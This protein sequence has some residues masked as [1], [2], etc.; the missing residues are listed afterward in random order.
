MPTRQ[1]A[2]RVIRPLVLAAPLIA[3]PAVASA[4]DFF[5]QNLIKPGTETFTLNLGGILN[6][7]DTRMRV[8][9]QTTTGTDI[10]LENNGMK[11]T[12]SSFFAAGTWRFAARHRLDADYFSAKRS[13]SRTYSDSITIGDNTYP[14]GATVSASSETQFFLADYRYSFMKTDS[15]E[16][17]GALGFYGGHFKFNA[18]A[19]ATGSGTSR[20]SSTSV[21]TTVPLPVVGATLDWYASPRLKLSGFAE[22][23]KANIGDVDGSIFV[24]GA[25]AEYMFARNLGAGL[26][27]MYSEVDVDVTKTN[28]NGNVNWRMNSVSLY[29]KLLF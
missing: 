3:G 22:G 13:G 29:A 9:G 6:Q 1:R 2:Y 26:R 14:L 28:F 5:S 20:S 7:F 11:D 23:M 8:N 19:V 18:D 4:Q 10:N 24:T 12:Q 21:S 25:A 15:V 16:L 27:Y 17:A